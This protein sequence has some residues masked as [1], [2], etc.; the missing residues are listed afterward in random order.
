MKMLDFRS[1]ERAGVNANGQVIIWL[2]FGG[3]AV[4]NFIALKSSDAAR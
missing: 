2:D 3:V 1:T 4:I